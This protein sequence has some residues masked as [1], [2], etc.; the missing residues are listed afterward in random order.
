MHIAIAIISAVILTL[1]LV[2]WKTVCNHT[3]NSYY[4]FPALFILSILLFAL[5][6]AAVYTP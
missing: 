5:S 1:S 6:L 3:N 2:T 4:S